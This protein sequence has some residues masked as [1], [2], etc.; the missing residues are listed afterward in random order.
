MVFRN[1][2]YYKTVYGPEYTTQLLS[3]ANSGKLLAGAWG[4][5]HT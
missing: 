2:K 4:E 3:H 5:Y 1:E